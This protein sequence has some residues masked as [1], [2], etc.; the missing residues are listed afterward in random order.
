MIEIRKTRPAS[1]NDGHFGRN[2]GLHYR[3]AARWGAFRD[4]VQVANLL[5]SSGYWGIWE[6]DGAVRD[7]AGRAFYTVAEAKAWARANL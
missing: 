6:G 5:H 3:S 4:G 7:L 1:N 2:S